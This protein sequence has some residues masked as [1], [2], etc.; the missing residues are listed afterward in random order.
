MIVIEELMFEFILCFVEVDV[1]G[2]LKLY[3]YEVGVGND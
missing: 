1:D 2:L 3:Y